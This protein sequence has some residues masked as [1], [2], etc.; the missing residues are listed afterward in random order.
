MSYNP[1]LRHLEALIYIDSLGS[2]NKASELIFLSQSALTQ[3][4]IKMERELGAI[5]FDR[6]ANGMYANKI[7][8]KFIARIRRASQYF[9]VFDKDLRS[10]QGTEALVRNRKLHLIASSAQLRAVIAVVEHSNISL[11]ASSLGLSQPS[12]QRSVRDLEANLKVKLFDRSATGVEPTPLA[13][14]LARFASLGL[15]EIQAGL[16]VVN[17]EQGKMTSKLFIGALPLARTEL[18]PASVDE[19]IKRFPELQISIIDGPYDE[20]LHAIL[21]SRVDMIIGALRQPNP[22]RE[23]EQHALFEDELSVV[24]RIGHPLLKQKDLKLADLSKFN[25]IAPRVGT[26]SRYRFQQIFKNHN[27]LEPTHIIECSSTVATRGLL[28]KSDRVSLLSKRQL[29]PEIEA[30]LLTTLSLSLPES[31]RPI[32][33]TV[34]KDWQATLSQQNYLDI[35]REISVKY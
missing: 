30:G 33:Y 12:V 10:Q 14:R 6:S 11:A 32:G 25:W 8:K 16:N 18:V 28:V 13:R 7:G 24:V 20:L 23:I 21:H 31:R 19:L 22:V 15:A 35:L 29:L 27:L 4:L 5:L 26:P 17:E 2:I 1:N 9:Q 34:R 3:G